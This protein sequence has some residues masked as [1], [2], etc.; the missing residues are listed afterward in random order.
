MLIPVS[1]TALAEVVGKVITGTGV[2]A[3]LRP[4]Q[5]YRVPKETLET[6]LDDIE[7]LTNFFV[8]EFQRILFAENVPVTIAVGLLLV[9]TLDLAS[10]RDRD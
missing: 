4:R 10:L 2:A 6:F 9:H 8:I 1:V 7:Q 5:Y 3:S